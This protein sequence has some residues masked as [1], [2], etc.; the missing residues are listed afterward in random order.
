MFTFSWLVKFLRK[1]FRGMKMLVVLV[2]PDDVRPLFRHDP[3][4]LAGD[5]PDEDRFP[6]GVLLAEELFRRG[7]ADEGDLALEA[8]VLL[9]D[10]A[11]LRDL[12]IPDLAE[13]RRDAVDGDRP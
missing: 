5:P 4:H 3:D 10:G 8:V 9:G 12:E 11:P 1:V 7:A 6:D 13:I 2:V